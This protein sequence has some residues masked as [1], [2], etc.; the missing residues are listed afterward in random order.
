MIPQREGK[1][2]YSIK[3]IGIDQNGTSVKILSPMNGESPIPIKKG[4]QLV[5]HE[6]P[7][8]GK[9]R[10]H[11]V[12]AGPN[13]SNP[14]QPYQYFD[15]EINKWVLIVQQPEDRPI[16]FRSAIRVDTSFDVKLT[17]AESNKE[18][19]AR[20]RDLSAT[21]MLLSVK[22]DNEIP[23]D[24]KVVLDF[25]LPDS[26]YELPPI[27]GKIVRVIEDKA[28]SAYLPKRY[29]IGVEFGEFKPL[30]QSSEATEHENE[31]VQ[32]KNDQDEI[33]RYVLEKQD[34]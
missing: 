19:K 9:P 10:S 18:Y 28:T 32:N 12:A 11:I 27:T 26:S 5:I 4:T 33:I 22:A 2:L 16:G 8:G 20:S 1:R 30:N 31:R 21:G 29:D 24:S 3:I 23:K 34:L 14:N 13:P 15:E 6:R 25:Q 7:K 17:V